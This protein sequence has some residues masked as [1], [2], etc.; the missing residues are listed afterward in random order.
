MSPRPVLEM[1]ITD[2]SHIGADDVSETR[3]EDLATRMAGQPQMHELPYSYYG[4]TYSSP[5][6]I[7]CCGEEWVR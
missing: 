5:A 4:S 6:S 1:E 7:C 3:W 2:V